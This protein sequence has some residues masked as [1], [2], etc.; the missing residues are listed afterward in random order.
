MSY[1]I[2]SEKATPHWGHFEASVLEEGQVEVKGTRR[3]V[4]DV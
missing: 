1:G 2:P 4:N 3:K